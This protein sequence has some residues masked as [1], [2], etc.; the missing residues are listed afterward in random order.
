MLVG[1]RLKT[2]IYPYL[3]F[4]TQDGAGLRAWTTMLIITTLPKIL[5]SS[6]NC[7]FALH[8]SVLAITV[9]SEELLRSFS[10]TCLI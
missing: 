4:V 9:G 2:I 7:L 5:K 3:L 8:V 6:I 10:Q 1:L